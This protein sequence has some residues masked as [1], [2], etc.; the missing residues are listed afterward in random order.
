MSETRTQILSIAQQAWDRILK[1]R[2]TP[3]PEMFALWYAYAGKTNSDIVK[4][5]DR[6]QVQGPLTDEQCL[7]LHHRFLS[8]ARQTERI[9]HA[10]D[11]VSL[12][13]RGLTEKVETVNAV[14]QDFTESL[15]VA[16]K[17]L[18]NAEGKDAVQAVVTLLNNETKTLIDK[19]QSLA[20]DM[21]VVMNQ[22]VVLQDELDAA[23]REALTDNLTGLANRKSFDLEIDR[24]ITDARNKKQPLSLLMLDIDHFKRFNDSFGHQVG[25]QVLRLVARTLK[26]GVKGRDFAARYGGEEFTIILPNTSLLAAAGLANQLIKAIAVKDIVNRTS[27]ESLGRITMSIGVSELGPAETGDSLITRADAAL[28]TAK[29]SGRNQMATA[30]HADREGL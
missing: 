9:L 8:D 13:I 17:K 4:N 18:G 30:P 5:I 3:L 25:D 24:Q 14:S 27:G 15:S 22:I 16:Q 19:N 12:A 20:A 26:E 28:Y 21:R 11:Q 2:L 1:D 6:L 23:R 7:E 10:G 29:H